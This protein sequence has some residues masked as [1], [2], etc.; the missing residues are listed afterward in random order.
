[1]KKVEYCSYFLRISF[2][3]AIL[4][5]S[6]RSDTDGILTRGFAHNWIGVLK[7]E[8]EKCK[9]NRVFLDS[10]NKFS[11]ISLLDSIYEAQGIRINSLE[12]QSY[13]AK[14]NHLR[15]KFGDGVYYIAIAND[16]KFH[17]IEFHLF[18]KETRISILDQE[19]FIPVRNQKE[20]EEHQPWVTENIKELTYTRFARKNDKLNMTS[21]FVSCN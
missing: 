6:C 3:L 1:M 2:L 19:E 14:N 9:N 17:R 15:D 8:N 13:H 7:E 21:V 16:K 12:I 18:P 20:L 10:E 4:L 5:M 11:L